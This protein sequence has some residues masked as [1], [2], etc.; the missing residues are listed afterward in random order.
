MRVFKPTLP[1][2]DFRPTIPQAGLSKHHNLQN[3]AQTCVTPGGVVVVVDWEC[4]EAVVVALQR[5]R[6]RQRCQHL[7]AHHQV[8]HPRQRQCICKAQPFL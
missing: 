5:G 4:G 7:G 2:Q 1:G 8:V 6:L 3:A